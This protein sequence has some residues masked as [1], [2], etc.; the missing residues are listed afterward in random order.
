[1]AGAPGRDRSPELE[2][3]R[4][5]A[6][7]NAGRLAGLAA[8]L[9]QMGE[10]IAALERDTDALVGHTEAPGGPSLRSWSP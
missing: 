3:I 4:R 10:R 5:L 6:V 8:Q 9:D 1:M 7:S 2:A